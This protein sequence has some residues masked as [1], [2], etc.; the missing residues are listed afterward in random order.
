MEKTFV[1]PLGDLPV[2]TK[3]INELKDFPLFHLAPD[4]HRQEHSLEMQLP[5]IKQAFGSVAL[6]PIIVGTLRSEQEMLL[7]GRI[8]SRYLTDGDIVLVSSDF[9]HYGP[10]YDFVPFIE[11]APKYVRELDEGAFEQLKNCDLRGFIEYRERTRDTICG[12]FPCTVLL[13]MLPPDTHATLLRYQTSRNIV[14]APDDNSVSYLAIVFSNNKCENDL[15]KKEA[16]PM[17]DTDKLDGQEKAALLALARKA[18]IEYANHGRVIDPSEV[19][20]QFPNLKQPAGVFVTLYKRKSLS[21]EQSL[22]NCSVPEAAHKELRGCIGYIW[23]VK[24]VAQAVVDNS[25]GASAKDPR[26]QPVQQSEIEGL[27]ID[28]NVLTPPHPVE[29]I[30]EIKLGQDGI[31]MYRGGCQSVFLPSVATEFGWTLEQTLTQLSL[32]A[33]CGS[34][35]WQSGSRFDVFQSESFSEL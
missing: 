17:H 8:L 10:R 11:D 3:T 20:S 12:F 21:A 35:G 13:S 32:K 22:K 29:S 24:S 28:I 27:Q 6:V 5:F 16:F 31:V 15:W 9:T 25:I 2:D 7:T 18:L 4:I 1:T 33:G 14:G 34:D 26:F 30:E 19:I 23:P